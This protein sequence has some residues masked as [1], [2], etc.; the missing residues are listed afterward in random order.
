M[1]VNQ[2]RLVLP[3]NV[4]FSLSFATQGGYAGNAL[5]FKL[6]SLSKLYE[7]R[8]NTARVT[9]LHFL[10][11]EAEKENKEILTFVEDLLPSL[12]QASR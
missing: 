9:L 7:I 12:K 3:T 10:V 5:G 8:A 2:S 4:A 11:Q 6:S 1:F